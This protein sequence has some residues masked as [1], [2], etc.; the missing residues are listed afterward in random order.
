M[1]GIIF[2]IASFLML[3]ASSYFL[4]SLIKSKKLANNV[5]YF[6]LI[7]ISLI[8]GQFQILSLLK[9]I[10]QG[11]VLG[12]NFLAFIF[13][14][15]LWE[16][17]SKPIIELTDIYAVKNKIIQ[18]LKR[19]K[20]LFILFW[21]FIF[22]SLITLFMAFIAPSNSP[23]SL[24]YHLAR[25]GAWLQNQSFQHYE[26]TDV[27]QN[28]YSINSEILTMWSMVFLKKDY[29]ASMLQYLSYIGCIFLLYAFLAYLKISTR[30][31][32]W[33]VFILACLPAAIIEA[34]S[35][36][37]DLIVAF[38]LFASF[39]LF[40]YGLKE[41][42]KKALIFSALAFGIN[43]GVKYSVFFFIPV[44]GLIY[45]FI[46]IKE[47]KKEFYKPLITFSIALFISFMLLSSYNY[48]AN[49]LHYG[50][51]FGTQPYLDRLQAP[52]TE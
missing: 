15:K 34:A 21:F 27:R 29:L 3:F 13:S 19:D 35:S 30:R 12:F 7:F 36:Q 37:M 51:M 39:F 31:I 18:A 47:K 46:A 24:T 23:D 41:N 33:S 8:I 11:A 45:L 25:I 16:A 48:I 50:N 17:K 2:F 44:F 43:I 28:I 22:S 38:L 32:L 4:T 1:S 40:I 20:I 5:I 14:Y 49:Y 52:R 42:S 10:T 6:I 26:T 9:F